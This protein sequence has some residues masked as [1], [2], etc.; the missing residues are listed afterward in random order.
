MKIKKKL[1]RN[2]GFS[3]LAIGPA[4][5]TL[6]KFKLKIPELIIDI[7]H[8]DLLVLFNEYF[9]PVGIILIIIGVLL[10]LISWFPSPKDIS[11]QFKTVL[12]RNKYEYMPI[13]AKKEDLVELYK[14]YKDLFG[15]DNIPIEQMESWFDKNNSILW[16]IIKIP[17]DDLDNNHELIGFFDIEPLTTNGEA[18]IRRETTGASELKKGDILSQRSKNSHSYYIGSVGSPINANL[19]D[20]GITMGFFVEKIKELGAN[21]TI[22]IY[23][24]PTTVKGM[25]LVKELFKMNKRHPGPDTERIWSKEINAGDFK[26]PGNYQ[27]RFS[28]NIKHQ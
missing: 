4:L 3:F 12:I 19:N 21:R 6:Y 15:D 5:L 20:K 28:K 18:K 25:Y 10:I 7:F 8:Y 2:I 14:H 27:K 23:A 26:L 11:D 24:K 22:N 16:K 1:V 13:Q 17:V 9:Q